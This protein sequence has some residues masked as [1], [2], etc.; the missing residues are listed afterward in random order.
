[1]N[2][3]FDQ[4][5]FCSWDVTPKLFLCDHTPISIG[6]WSKAEVFGQCQTSRAFGF[7]QTPLDRLANHH[8]LVFGQNQK[9]EIGW[10]HIGQKFR[11]WIASPK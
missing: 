2:W 6:G 4:N 10:Y 8:I 5:L 1:L 3:G 9:L 7:G 11:L